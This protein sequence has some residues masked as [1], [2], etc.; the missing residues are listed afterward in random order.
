MPR[1]SLPIAPAPE[2]AAGASIQI[3]RPQ[4][5]ATVSAP[6]TLD[7]KVVGMRLVP[8]GVD[9]SNTGHLHVLVDAS[10]A[11]SSGPIPSDPQHIDFGS[12]ES[13][14][15]LDLPAGRHTLQLLL[16]DGSHVPHEPPVISEQISVTVEAH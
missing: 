5:G 8:A 4:D 2:A 12:G 6:F 15:E 1:N 16:G 3:V 9:E 7:A 11:L 10:S 14:G 13:R